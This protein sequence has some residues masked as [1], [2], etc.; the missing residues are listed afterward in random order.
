MAADDVQLPD[1]EVIQ[2]FS[3]AVRGATAPRAEVVAALQA[4]LDW[5]TSGGSRP[6]P[7]APAKVTKATK[8]AP[9]E[10]VSP[11]RKRAARRTVPRTSPP[12]SEA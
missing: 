4:D 5:L 3:L 10:G 7:P 11:P 2:R 1:L 12:A 6:A 9:A 8:A